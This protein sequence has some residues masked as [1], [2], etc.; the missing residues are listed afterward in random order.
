MN[1]VVKLFAG[2]RTTVGEREVTVEMPAGAT[3]GGVLAV[4]VAHHPGLAPLA[5][6]LRVAVNREY[7]EP[8]RVLTD[9]DEVALLPPVSGGLDQL[10]ITAEPLSLETIARSVTRSSSGAIATFVGVV[11][12]SSRGRRVTS[13][14]YEA[15]PEMAVATLG[16][17]AAEIRARW[18]VDD[19]AIVH[20]VGRLVVGEA[21]IVIAV[22][23]PHRRE[24]LAACALAIERVK[25]RAPIWKREVWADGSEWIG[26]TADEY[27]ELH[28]AS[29]E[30]GV[31][32]RGPG[33]GEQ[34]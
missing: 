6:V 4:M 32:D 19:V 25:E 28:G 15:Y 7:A 14:E 34:P 22:S 24:A 17:I 18:A 13:L 16:E 29:Y 20:R 11:R 33:A 27:R 5:G 9:G 30:T 26:S 23:S 3:A 1:V 2:A 12:E 31:R 21:S 10:D 8:S